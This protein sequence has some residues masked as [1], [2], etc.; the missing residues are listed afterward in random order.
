MQIRQTF[1][2]QTYDFSGSNP[3]PPTKN[4]NRNMKGI[5]YM[6]YIIWFM[7]YLKVC[8]YLTNECNCFCEKREKD[9]GDIYEERCGF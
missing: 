4:I 3:L 2:A 9:W 6:Y 8:M 5:L 7:E 1:I